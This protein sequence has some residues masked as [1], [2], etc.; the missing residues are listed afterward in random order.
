MLHWIALA[1][2]HKGHPDGKRYV[3]VL[4]ALLE[5]RSAGRA[6]FPISDSIFMETSQIRQHRQRQDLC[7]VIELLSGFLVVTSR[8]IVSAHEIESLLN[9]LVGPRTRPINTTDYL[10][11]GVSRAFGM[12]GGFKVLDENGTDITEA[13][14]RD[15]P[16][17]IEAFDRF[18]AEAE[19][20]LVRNALA[21]P[22]TEEEPY[23][24]SIGWRGGY[25]SDVG[26]RRAEQEREQQNLFV[27]NPRWRRGRLRDVVSARELMIEINDLMVDGLGARGVALADVA[28]DP[29]E[30]RAAFDS[31][32]SFDVAVTIKV[33]YHE[34][35]SHQWTENDIH[36]IDALGST[37]PY[38]DIVL[39]DKAAAGQLYRTGLVDR[40]GT[41]VLTSLD[42][43]PPLL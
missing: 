16:G 19:V 11:W 1:K 25:E 31:M 40:M 9:D 26:R 34:N 43:L 41:T 3:P 28:A 20:D 39:P 21:G 23:M 6:L 14:R 12:V 13:V 38:C 42:D 17:G 7:N 10:D 30:F 2:A 35:P 18:F 15:H 24:R 8:S 22:T 33:A 5:A 27:A 36:D 29:E 37:V 32:P 4:E